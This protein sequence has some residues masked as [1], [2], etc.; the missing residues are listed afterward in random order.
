MTEVPDPPGLSFGKALITA[1]TDNIFCRS[2]KKKNLYA[3]PSKEL[4]TFAILT[5]LDGLLMSIT[6]HLWIWD[7]SI[8]IMYVGEWKDYI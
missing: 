3:L 7:I 5:L 4:W 1:M 2:Q 8:R 6:Q